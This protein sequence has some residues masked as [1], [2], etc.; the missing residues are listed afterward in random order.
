MSQN[1]PEIILL[2]MKKA[3]RLDIKSR[4]L[5]VSERT[6]FVKGF[7]FLGLSCLAA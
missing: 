2:M 5:R 4:S 7:R 1:Y 6:Q 3:P